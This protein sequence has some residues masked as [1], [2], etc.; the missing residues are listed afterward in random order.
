MTVL[1]VVDAVA[2][3]QTVPHEFG[4]AGVYPNPFNRSFQVAYNLES[5]MWVNL[6]LVD[7]N[8]RG[9]ELLD[10]HQ[11]SGRRELVIDAHFLPSGLYLLKLETTNWSDVMKV[12]CIR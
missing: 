7:L 2:D 11:T 9:I 3:N 5:A 12:I 4:I 6:R 1:P 10:E 8:G